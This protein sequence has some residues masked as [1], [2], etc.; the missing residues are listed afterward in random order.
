[1][2]RSLAGTV[3]VDGFGQQDAQGHQEAQKQY[4]AQSDDKWHVPRRRRINI[5]PQGLVDDL[6]LE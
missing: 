5:L 4:G 2:L 6:G 3:S 1:M